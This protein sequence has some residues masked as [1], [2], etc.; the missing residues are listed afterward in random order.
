M[1]VVVTRSKHTITTITITTT[2][3]IATTATLLFD[4]FSH[5]NDC[6]FRGDDNLTSINYH[7]HTTYTIHYDSYYSYDH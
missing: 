2:T 4:C 7:G 6:V 1:K 5:R 3:T